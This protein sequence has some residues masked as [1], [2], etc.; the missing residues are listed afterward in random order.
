M[1]LLILGLKQL[2]NGVDVYLQSLGDELK[3]M[4]IDILETYDAL[5]IETLYACCINV[6]Y[7]NHF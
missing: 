5:Q 2:G 6:A 1:P 4:L 7:I 3:D